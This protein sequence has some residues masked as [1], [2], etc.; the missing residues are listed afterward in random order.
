MHG[1]LQLKLLSWYRQELCQGLHHFEL[2]V[3]VDFQQ[4]RHVLWLVLQGFQEDSLKVF[5]HLR[6][7]NLQELDISLFFVFR[8]DF[9]K[10]LQ[11][12]LEILMWIHS[13]KMFQVLSKLVC[14]FFQIFVLHKLVLPS[15]DLYIQFLFHSYLKVLL[16]QQLQK[17]FLQA[18][19]DLVVFLEQD[20]DW[21]RQQKFFSSLHI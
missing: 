20:Q 11:F 14:W 3:V 12:L 5:Q 8:Q 7:L 2:F 10:V 6:H 13:K 19:D 21:F 4:E 18:M 9:S 15:L 16:F 17:L 1:T